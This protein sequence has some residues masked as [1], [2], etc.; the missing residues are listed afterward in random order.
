MELVS[1]VQWTAEEDELLRLHYP[2]MGKAAAKLFFGK[3][4]QTACIGRAKV[5]GLT[6][7][8]N[9]RPWSEAEL[10]VL[11]NGYPEMG[12]KISEQLPGRSAIS[13][14]KK[15]AKMGLSFYPSKVDRADVA[16]RWSEQELEIL[17]K[18]YP[19]IGPE[20][21]TLL[22]NRTK[23]ACIKMAMSLGLHYGIKKWSAEEDAVMIEKYPELGAD[24]SEL[25][26]GRTKSACHSRAKALRIPRQGIRWTAEEDDVLRKY[27]PVEDVKAFQRLPNRTALACDSRAKKLG[28]YRPKAANLNNPDPH[29]SEET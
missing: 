20:T 14:Q 17:K 9:R 1:P 27:Y 23:T 28:L 8:Q 22:P 21:Y 3:R 29:Q 10:S 2:H 24:V 15:A 16:R 19:Q 12:P 5:L 7:D 25:L 13:C 18:N 26:P 6:Y 11:E 4:T